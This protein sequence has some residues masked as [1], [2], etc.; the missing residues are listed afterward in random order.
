VP[1]FAELNVQVVVELREALA[2]ES[3]RGL[4]EFPGVRE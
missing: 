4:A 1:V 2:F 3:F